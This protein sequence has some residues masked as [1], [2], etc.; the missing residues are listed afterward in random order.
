MSPE[1]STREDIAIIGLAGRF[2]G[3]RDLAEF[4]RNLRD[5]VESVTFFSADEL[6]P[7]PLDGPVPAHDPHLVKARALLAQPEWFDAAFFG[8]NP[9]EAE[10]MDP[11]HRLLLECAWEALEHAGVNPDKFPGAIGVFA[12]ASLNTYL[13]A[14]ILPEGAAL[15]RAGGFQTL[16]ASDKDF[17]TT[18]ISYKLNLRG[19]S[20]NVQTACSTSLVTVCLGCQHLLGYQCDLALAGGVSVSFPQKRALLHQE[21]GIVSPDG[22]CRPF[23]QAAAGTVPGDGAGLVVLKRLS[24]AL[25][26]GDP[27]CAVIRGSAVNNDGALK[28]GYTAPSIAGQAEVIA[29]ALAQAGVAPETVSYVET[30]GTGTPLGD[31]IE[32]AGLTKA[33]GTRATGYCA[34]GATKAN[35]GHLDTAAGVAGLI[36]TVLA[37][38]HRQLPPL[39]HFREPNSKIDFAASPFVPNARLRD[40]PAAATPRR[41]GVSSFGIGGTNAH[42][43]LEE[44]P[45]APPAEPTGSPQLLVWSA[46]SRTALDA[47]T[48]NLADCLAAQPAPALADVAWTLQ[49]GRK[50]FPHRRVCLCRE[51]TDAVALLRSGDSKRIFETESAETDAPV[52]FL[53]P[54]QGAQH[55]GMG[56]GLYESEPVFRETVD[57]CCEI[58]RDPLGLDLRDILYPDATRRDEAARLLGQTALTQPALFVT[59]YALAQLW[60]SRG[61]RARALLGHSLGEY[62]AACLAGVFTLPDAL[63]LVAARA[64]LVQQQPPGAMVA[65]RVTEAE[66]AALLAPR[67]SLAAVNAP[68]LCV[69]SGP[70]PDIVALE[71]KLS[72]AGTVSRRLATSHAF[73]SEM[74]EPAVA[75]FLAEVRRVKLHPPAISL[76][77]NITGDWLKPEQATD[78][79]YWASHLRQ[80]VRF[81]GGVAALLQDSRSVLLEVGPGQ[82]LG[83]LARQHPSVGAAHPVVCSLGR[84]GET[85]DDSAAWLTALGK[86]WLA[87]VAVDWAALHAPAQ[88]HRV[89]LPTYPFERKRCWIEP[90]ALSPAFAPARNGELSRHPFEA[91]TVAT[92]PDPVPVR[93][94]SA[95]LDRLR[96]LFADLSGT[97]LKDTGAQASFSELGFD[98]LFLTQAS[99]A[100]KEQFGAEISMRQLQEE[101]STLG[102][103]ADHLGRV[104]ATPPPLPSAEPAPL[105]PAAIAPDGAVPLTEA[106]T[107]IWFAAQM[108]EAVSA[109]YNESCIVHL[110][111]LIDLQSLHFAVQQLVDRHD[112]L[113]TTFSPAGDR[114]RIAAAAWFELPVTALGAPT[115]N[116]G[117]NPALARFVDRAVEEPFDLVR[118]PLWRLRLARL[119]GERHALVLVAHHIVCDGWSL[120]LLAYELGQLYTA[121]RRGHTA[122]L[123]APA[124]FGV[125]ALHETERRNTPA[126]AAAETFWLAQFAGEVPVLDLPSDRPRPAR[127]SY[128]GAHCSR[129][130]PADL[131]DLVRRHSAAHGCTIFTVLLAAFTTLLHR[132]S[133]QDDVV[134]GVPAAAQILGGCQNLAGHCVNLL[135]IRS[136]LGENETAAD[137]LDATRRRVLD[138]FEH[139]Q[140]PFGALLRRLNLPRDPNRVPLTNVTFNLG[141]QHGALHYGETK[142]QLAGG[143][144]RFVN[145]DLN[146]NVT[147]ADGSLTVDC[148]YSTELFDRATVGRML[149]RYEMLL[150]A[151]AEQPAQTV[152][153]LPLLTPDELRQLTV[154]WN[155]TAADYPAGVCLHAM[156]TQQARRSPAAVALVHGATRWTYRDLSRRANQIAHRL[157]KLGVNAGSLVGLCTARTPAMIAGVLGILKAGGA[158]VPLDPAYQAE[159]LA[160]MLEDSGAAALVADHAPEFPLPPALPAAAVLRLNEHWTEQLAGEKTDEPADSVT[161]GDLAYVIYTSGSTGRPKGV[162]IE[163]RNTVAFAHWAHDVFTAEEL[164][165]VLAA[166]SLCF[167]LSVFEIFVPLTRGGAVILADNALQLSALPA[168]D[169]VTLINSVPSAVTELVRTEAIPV[170]VRTVNL[171]GEPLSAALVR[172]LAALPSVQ[173]VYDLYGPTETTTYSTVALRRPDG[174]VTIGRPIANTQIVLLDRHRELV[175]PGLPG[176]I[177]IGGAGVA[178]GY[179]H[180]PELTAEKFVTLAVAGGEPARFYR[181]GDLARHLPDGSLEYLGRLDHQVKIRG[182]RIELDEI[183]AQLAQ[184]PGVR[185][186]AVVVREDQPGN[187]GLVAYFTAGTAAPDRTALRQALARTLPDHMLPA[188]FVQ[189]DRLPR[190]PNGKLDRRALPAPDHDRAAPA[191][192]F[193]A[194]RTTTEEVL[195]EIWCAVLGRDRVGVHDNF[196]DLGGHSL[197]VAQVLARVR[198]AFQTNLPLRRAFES[199]TIAQLAAAVEQALIAEIAAQAPETDGRI[200]EIVSAHATD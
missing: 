92:L 57:R 118:G 167:D 14:N 154:D 97:D 198:Q 5:G 21:G 175:P 8:I 113:R 133:G 68:T 42:V 74:M 98:S 59:E 177:W 27:I 136:R 158:Y 190:T 34:L 86:L 62:V 56:R 46:K 49:T 78:P 37:L 162:A 119:G 107:E 181:T 124:L 20:L 81:A 76:V 128:A 183:A 187:R 96:R 121:L 171:A 176:E 192:T 147:D 150:R 102:K 100:L 199:P 67:L 138:A 189:L 163:H 112:S 4:W 134:V 109:A 15:R 36:K 29:L 31:P 135:P 9:R 63:T 143:P 33:F 53:F 87:G 142:V 1:A 54:G 122:Q 111:G 144:K 72:A 80:P 149:E 130:L 194:P 44:A 12:G 66:V 60:M 115:E 51:T 11:Q 17:L 145:F 58:L 127:R 101:C 165:G 10:L 148:H 161:P 71:E 16:L 126:Y 185:D 116:G 104:A 75:A 45:A 180:R 19:P 50:L 153:R 77:S 103:L 159:R 108:D 173:K 83:P 195:A 200:S 191:E 160:F 48:A 22:H 52:A 139:W 40:W 182:Y 91:A 69:I 99:L 137:F 39:L 140:H 123:P 151:A 24:E 61:I 2:P 152:H 170:S 179:L 166:T 25:A 188:A 3:A 132:L 82:T 7:S 131:A 85:P 156:F 55:V 157:R 174:P 184:Q 43:V 88:R 141:R 47:M 110:H 129:P 73:H 26:D 35:I 178:R 197:L 114:Q 41:A 186:S 164:R 105:P 120:R 146:F 106:Q 95:W 18:R 125:F 13:L 79:A 155:R 117:E 38:Q 23:D 172:Q 89:A 32:I 70:V 168:R 84:P 28:I 94:D 196:F 193:V 64:R 30:H 6:Q 90:P 65:V 169:E 93:N